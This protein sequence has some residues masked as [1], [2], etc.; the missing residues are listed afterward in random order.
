VQDLVPPHRN[1][2]KMRGD[3]FDVEVLGGHLLEIEAGA[4]CLAAAG[5]DD[6]TNIVA[7]F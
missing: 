2:A 7:G 1:N 5:Q 6:G 3:G 4:E